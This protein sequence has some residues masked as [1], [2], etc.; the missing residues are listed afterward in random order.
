MRTHRSHDRSA[1]ATETESQ[2]EH[3]AVAGLSLA[4]D[5]LRFVADRTAFEPT[6][7]VDWTFRLLDER[8]DPVKAFEESHGQ[9]SH[10]VVVRRDLIA[11]QHLHPSLDESGT[12]HCDGFTLPLGGVYRAFVDVV[13]GGRASTLG[14][15]LFASGT[16][17]VG[18]A[19]PSEVTDPEDR[20]EVELQSERTEAGESSRLSFAVSRADGTVPDLRP[21]LGAQGHLVALRAGDLA[22]LHV[23]P[24]ETEAE[25]RVEFAATFPTPGE[26][27]LFLQTRPDGILR[28][29]TFDIEV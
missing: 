17:D 8:D 23:H 24:T 29:T 13:V 2:T 26:Y 27:R 20:Y 12:W 1:D 4:T 6:V 15:D 19:L 9:R 16:F 5:G 3:G 7:S 10:L 25:G 28:T 21:Y 14:L 18:T 11:F 22:Y